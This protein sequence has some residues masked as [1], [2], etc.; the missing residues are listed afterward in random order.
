MEFKIKERVEFEVRLEKGENGRKKIVRFLRNS[1]KENIVRKSEDNTPILKQYNGENRSSK[2]QLFF[3]A[4]SNGGK[5]VGACV[6]EIYGKG[7][8][9]LDLLTVK[10]EHQ[11]QG[12]GLA[13][14]IYIISYAKK[15]GIHNIQCISLISDKRSKKFLKKAGFKKAGKLKKYLG[16]QDYYIWE[17]LP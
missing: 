11:R 5:V 10:K 12:V 13:I 9:R 3:M 8:L 15:N 7:L 14:I 1:V 17:Y 16:K 4:Y 2:N 6:S